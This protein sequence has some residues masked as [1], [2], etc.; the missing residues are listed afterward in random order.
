MFCQ[1]F[2]CRRKPMNNDARSNN[3]KSIFCKVNWQCFAFDGEKSRCQNPRGT[4]D[5]TNKFSLFCMK[6]QITGIQKYFDELYEAKRNEKCRE[7]SR[8]VNPHPKYVRTFEY[9]RRYF[10]LKN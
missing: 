4:T 10:P 2:S 7:L 5:Q 8:C 3:P 1:D 9:I 6:H